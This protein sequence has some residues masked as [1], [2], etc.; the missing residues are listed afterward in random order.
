VVDGRSVWADG[1]FP[2]TLL[3]ALLGKVYL[4]SLKLCPSTAH[5]LARIISSTLLQGLSQFYP[6][7]LQMLSSWEGSSPTS[8]DVHVLFIF[9]PSSVCLSARFISSISASF[10][11]S[12]SI[13]LHCLPVGKV[14]F[15]ISRKV[16]SRDVH[17]LFVCST[18]C[19]LARFISSSLVRFL[20]CSSLPLPCPLARLISF[21][22]ANF[23][24][25]YLLPFR[26]LPVS[27]VNLFYLS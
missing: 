26:C 11:S 24:S 22:S 9:C 27:K 1:A 21:I 6:Y 7:A 23:I 13:A 15:P 17:I 14:H 18:A 19:L 2:T 8:C 25:C 12:L 4:L 16:P 20:S 3:A 5:P 10:I